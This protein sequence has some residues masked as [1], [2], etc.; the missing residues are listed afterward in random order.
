MGW[1]RDRNSFGKGGGSGKEMD[2]L[3]KNFECFFTLSMFVC[4]CA[5]G[6]LP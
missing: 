5:V 2:P 4:F 1:G 3:K 6:L